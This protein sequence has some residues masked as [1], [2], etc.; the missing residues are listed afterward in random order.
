[1]VMEILCFDIKV[2]IL[3]YFMWLGF[4]FGGFC[5]LKD[6]C[7]LWYLVGVKDVLVLLLN[8]VLEVNE[9]Q[10]VKVEKMVVEFKVK[11]V[12]F[13]GISFKLGIDDL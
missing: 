5:L 7:V 4:V 10:I 9:V 2:N 12:G 13:V 6:V 3:F 1:M 8:V 11:I